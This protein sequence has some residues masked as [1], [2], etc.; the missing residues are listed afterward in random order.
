MTMTLR[1]FLSGLG[2]FISPFP[3]F[4]QITLQGWI[5]D[6]NSRAAIGFANVSLLATSNSSPQTGTQADSA[7]YFTLSGLHPGQYRLQVSFLGYQT[8]FRDIDL[9][10]Q[11][12]VVQL[13]PF[14]L[15]PDPK[16]LG[17]VTVRGNANAIRY[18]PGKTILRVAGNQL[19]KSSVNA[20]DVLG[21]A[22]GVLVNPDGTLLLSGRNT[23]TVFIDGKPVVMSPEEQ[24]A[25]LRGLTPEMIE[26]IEV[27]HNPS[28]R[29]DGQYTAIIDIR[30]KQNTETGLKGI[31]SSAVRRNVY[32]QADNNLSLSYRNRQT[33]YSLLAGYVVGDDYYQ[34]DALQKLAAG[35][36]MKTQTY[37]RT[38]NNNLNVQLT[39]AYVLGKRQTIDFALKAYHANRDMGA[40]NTL[41]FREPLGEV[42]QGINQT[43]TL[44]NPRQRN[45]A[46]NAAYDY[47]FSKNSNLTIFGLLRTV[48]NR[49]RED[50]QIR[51]QLADTLADYWKTALKNDIRIRSLQA[52]YTHSTKTGRW[53]A[54]VK[55]VSITTDNDLR[56]DTL[57]TDGL[58][59]RD[60]GRTN[61]FVYRESISAGYMA[62]EYRAGKFNV[63]LNTR[64][65]YTQT[66]AHSVTDNHL[67]KRNYLNL[68][69]GASVTYQLDESHRFS[70]FFTS[71]LTRPD[72]DQLNPFRFYLSPL[73]YRVGNPNLIASAIRSLNLSWTRNELNVTASAGREKNLLTRYPEYNRVTNE[74]LYLGANLPF[75]D[76]ASLET[77]YTFSPFR[78]WKS[79]NTVGIYYRKQKMPYLG[80][81]YAIGV[82]DFT[83]NGNQVF[84]L[85]YGITADLGY[86][87]RSWSGNSL[88]IFKPM[89]SLDIGVQKNWWQGKLNSRLNVYDLFYTY[90]TQFVFREKAIIDNQLA[91]RIASRRVV[92]T[93]ALNIGKATYKTKPTRTSDEENRA[94]R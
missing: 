46:F 70:I 40:Y 71:R 72:F 69:P 43:V 36:F 77:G 4:A 23:P 75:S 26:S 53:E 54:G 20:L 61:Q 68:L 47:K 33:T 10:A 19:F 13:F 1:F 35:H 12:A 57:A 34:Y 14:L 21:R 79:I 85:P 67:R 82:T 92:L 64:G 55:F 52:D 48:R 3:L 7:G 2:F 89:G 16:Q 27:I 94:G 25:Y 6:S 8:G 9:A 32:T 56:Y 49:Q 93:L 84:S 30:L 41:T 59:V 38:A 39:A 63:K 17:E 44:S 42:V 31:I 74:L 66:V 45:Y 81:V 83:I 18:E 78:W 50:I 29:Y 90:V 86:R 60:A 58:F 28:S 88:Y 22:P 76:F 24:Q 87:Y 62:Y 91:H 5:T 15:Q 11:P 51:D 37:T 73:N 80:N 65:E